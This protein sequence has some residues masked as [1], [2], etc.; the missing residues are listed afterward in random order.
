MLSTPPSPQ[1]EGRSVNSLRDRFLDATVAW[2]FDASGFRRH[3]Q[4]FDRADL[5][6]DLGGAVILVT[7]ANSG[8]GL[9]TSCQLARLGATVWMLCRDRARG[10]AALAR[11]TEAA[12]HT[13]RLEI[14]DVS[15]LASVRAF[16][17]ARAPARF[18]A[19]VHNAGALDSVRTQT[20]AGLEQTFAT[21]V[22]G[23]HLLTALLG[24]RCERVVFV[25][26][27]GMYTQRLEVDALFDPPQP[28]DGVRA[29]AQCK[30]AQLVL[31]RV[32]AER[33]PATRLSAMH[34]GWAATPGV[35]RSLPAFERWMQGRLRTPDEGADTTTWLV[36]ATS[37]GL[38]SGRFW[39]DRCEAQE[40]AVPGT[41]P[42]A[43]AELALVERLDALVARF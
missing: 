9:A 26:S 12:R 11:V 2:N 1:S 10:E 13:P 38:P 34:P 4:R 29:Y 15:D 36:A 37:S 33:L 18:H 28:F 31:A 41:R 14:L 17:S 5:E 22:A 30:R 23:P 27:G 35:A 8:L 39:F 6:V 3:A 20:A 21:H 7:G 25:S 40:F 16:A 43:G 24:A 19:L 42:R 32:W